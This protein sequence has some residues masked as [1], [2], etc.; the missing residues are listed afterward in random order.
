MVP[1]NFKATIWPRNH[2]EIIAPVRNHTVEGMNHR[3]LPSITTE[4]MP[5]RAGNPLHRLRRED[6]VSLRDP[7]LA[8]EEI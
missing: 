7:M 6:A 1:M 2:T 8:R 3:M 4:S 5:V